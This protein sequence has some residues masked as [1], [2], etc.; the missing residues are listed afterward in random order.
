MTL[1]FIFMEMLVI[2]IGCRHFSDASRASLNWNKS[3]GLWVSDVPRPEWYPGPELRWPNN[4]EP[5]RYL[6]YLVGIDLSS[7]AM[8]SPLLLS[9][10]RKLV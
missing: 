4:G 7:E 8:L 9:I 6:G 1:L 3:I 10:K 2:L 5:M